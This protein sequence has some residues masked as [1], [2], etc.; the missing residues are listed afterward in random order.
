MNSI[1]VLLI[2]GVFLLQIGLIS[3]EKDEKTHSSSGSNSYLGGFGKFID[4]R[5]NKEYRWVNIGGQIWMA[6][7]LA[8]KVDTGGCWSYW[9]YDSH[10]NIVEKYGYLYNRRTAML[11]APEGWHIPSQHEWWELE[12]Y[13]SDNIIEDN[14]N[15]RYL[16]NKSLASDTGWAASNNHLAIGNNDYGEYRNESGFSALPG[17]YRDYDSHYKG[18]TK[19]GFRWTST[20]YDENDC[21][22]YFKTLEYNSMGYDLDPAS[23]TIAYSVRCIKDSE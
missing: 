22:T 10:H 6:E 18:L 12:L 11:V 7:N 8:Y 23:N 17:G 19:V 15:K 16:V 13:I 3:C 21:C 5:D 9:A 14:I 1:R 4:N 20:Q 2:I